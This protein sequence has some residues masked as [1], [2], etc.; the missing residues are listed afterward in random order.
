MKKINF[1][2]TVILLLVFVASPVPAQEMKKIAQAGVQFLKIDPVARSASLG[3]A[4]TVVDYSSSAMFYN[5]AGM[6]RMEKQFDINFNTNQWIADIQYNSFGAAYTFEGIGTF[7]INGIFSDY[8]DIPGAQLA[9]NEDG[10]I[11]TDNIDVN[12][13]AVGISYAVNLSSNFAIGATGRYISQS[14]GASLMNDNSTKN[15]EVSGL[16]FDFGTVFYPGWES[17]RFGISVKNFGDELTYERESFETP[18]TFSIG[19]AMNVLDLTSME[20]QTLL[21]TVD[22]VHPRDYTERVKMGLEY[23]LFNMFA[24]RAGYVTNHDVMSAS[25]GLGFFYDLSGVGLR[26]DYAY[27]D[28]EYF[29]AVQRISAG[30]SF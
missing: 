23:L 25:L 24:F 1:A 30:F 5:P 29:D 14:L 7:G 15:N 27:S 28:T 26:I 11:V 12:A 18:L 19:V 2:T 20:D 16:T 4:M 10:Y 9:D 8:G 13:Y 6:A 17:F 22:A 21:V 3:G